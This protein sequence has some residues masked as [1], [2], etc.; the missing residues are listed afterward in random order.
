M[1]IA[2]SLG[3]WG[4]KSQPLDRGAVHNGWVEAHICAQLMVVAAK[5]LEREGHTVFMLAHDDYK[6]RQKFANRMRCDVF[7][8]LHMNSASSAGDYGLIYYDER[9]KLG[10][11]FALLLA[12]EFE[13]QL[14]WD[15]R[16]E[17]LG[18]S[19]RGFNNIKHT[20]MTALLL[21]PGFLNNSRHMRALTPLSFAMA[22]TEGIKRFEKVTR[23]ATTS[24]RSKIKRIFASKR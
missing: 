7:F 1:K 5:M 6:N 15:F 14:P 3:H 21:E 19:Q 17:A 18:P 9:G 13:K 4:K 20:H 22:L 16:V 8:A 23:I 12:G 10:K 11:L 24:Q 2:L